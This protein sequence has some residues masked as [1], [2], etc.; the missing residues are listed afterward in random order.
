VTV[1][2]RDLSPDDVLDLPGPDA[3]ASYEQLL[4]LLSHRRSVRR[5][6]ARE[7]EPE[8]V[9]RLLDAA[10]TAPMGVPPSEVGVLVLEGREKVSAYAAEATAWISSAG[11]WM[12]P[13]LPLMRPFLR[14]DDYVMFRDFVLP[15]ARIYAEKAETGT[16]WLMYDAPLAMIFYG[17]G[18]ND[19]ADPYIPATLAVVAA[20]SLGLGS[21][22]LGFAGYPLFYSK[23]ARWRHGLP[24]RVRPGVAVIF[25][26]ASVQPTHGIARR[27]SRVT[28]ER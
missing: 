8:I 24:D 18:I 28:R 9:E 6:T 15:A 22:M 19:P 11:R 25:G 2:G 20:E 13:V 7:V 23:K 26:Y 5:F 3:R 14:R 17:T 21:C 16:D 12:R 27:F 4:A 10:S 1:V